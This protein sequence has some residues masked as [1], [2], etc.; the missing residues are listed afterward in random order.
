MAILMIGVLSAS[1]G[2][3]DANVP[4]VGPIANT[5][6]PSSELWCTGQKKINQPTGS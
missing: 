2:L 3:K 6:T 4:K 1:D 5:L